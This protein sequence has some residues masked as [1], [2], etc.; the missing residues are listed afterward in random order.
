MDTLQEAKCILCDLLVLGPAANAPWDTTIAETDKYRIV[1]TKGSLV[2]GWL[3]AV[4]K[5]HALCSGELETHELNCLEKAI[6]VATEFVERHFGAAT[7]F[8][9][10]PRVAGTSLG[11]GVDH[12]HFHVAPL[13][14]SLVEAVDSVVPNA[15]WAKLEGLQALRTLHKAGIGYA[16]VGEPGG[17]MVGFQPTANIRQPLRRAIANRLGT[18][19]L[20]D[21]A[22]HPH[23]ENVLRTLE[24]VGV[25]A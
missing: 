16:V 15:R 25:G 17:G 18:P 21:Y 13:K 14:F 1:P 23:V 3:L 22:A 11:C 19:E 24:H 2:P 4:S 10:G 6:G 12:L 7:I 20:F 9:H 8:E 5:S